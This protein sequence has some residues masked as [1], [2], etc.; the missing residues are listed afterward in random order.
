MYLPEPVHYC[1]EALEKAGYQGGY[2][3]LAHC[4]N[5]PFA[6]SLADAISLQFPGANIQIYETRG[7]CS[8]YAERGGVLLGF[9][10]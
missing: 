2:I 5:I 9:E 4:E 10:T 8:Y 3:C 7:L 6:T 1:I